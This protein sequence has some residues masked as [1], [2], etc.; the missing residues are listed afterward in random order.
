MVLCGISTLTVLRG[1]GDQR[2]PTYHLYSSI[3]R[4]AKKKI[5]TIYLAIKFETQNSNAETLIVGL[6]ANR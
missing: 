3:E 4:K 5:L 2:H 6:N 1:K